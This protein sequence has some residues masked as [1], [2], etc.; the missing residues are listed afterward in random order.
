[1]IKYIAAALL[2]A[3][4]VHLYHTR[5][6]AEYQLEQ[7]EQYNLLLEQRNELFNKNAELNFKVESERLKTYDEQEQK[8]SK[9]IADMRREF[10]P[11]GV[12]KCPT[13]ETTTASA[14]SNTSGI[15]C[16]KRSELYRKIEASL[17]IGQNC[18]RIAADYNAL[19]QIVKGFNNEA[20]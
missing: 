6:F 1:M 2:S 20:K 17:A 10:K 4:L 7:Q 15:V 14:N 12:L 13:R 8:Y 9:I 19:L 5:N 16:Y 3:L 11:S 18:D